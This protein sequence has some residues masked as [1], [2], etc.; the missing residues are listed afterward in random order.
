MHQHQ[1]FRTTG[2]L[3]YP[4]GKRRLG[5]KPAS[6]FGLSRDRTRLSCDR[7]GLSYRHYE[8]TAIDRVL[9][10]K[11]MVSAEEDM[12]EGSDPDQFEGIPTAD[13]V[14]DFDLTTED[15][16]VDPRGKIGKALLK[17]GKVQYRHVDRMPSWYVPTPTY[18]L[19]LERHVCLDVS[20]KSQLLLW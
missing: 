2:H 14:T 12:K 4:I 8:I 20:N 3:L 15:G 11:P 17:M 19:Q 10:V 1:W 16:D 18:L 9:R 6:I 13:D 7:T 5:T